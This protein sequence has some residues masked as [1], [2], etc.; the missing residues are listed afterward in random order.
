MASHLSVFCDSYIWSLY[1]DVNLGFLL[2]SDGKSPSKQPL[3]T[4]KGKGKG[5]AKGKSPAK[6][7]DKVPATESDSEGPERNIQA[8][9]FIGYERRAARVVAEET[10]KYTV[11]STGRC[12]LPGCDSKGG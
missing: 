2:I 10:M 6:G 11:D 12:P 9:L 7:K 3:P 5:K 4:A 1:P 8:A